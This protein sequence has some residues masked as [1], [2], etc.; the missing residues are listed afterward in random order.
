ML[1][2]QLSRQR[3]DACCISSSSI[4]T[5]STGNVHQTSHN[6]NTDGSQ[7]P[8][9][10]EWCHAVQANGRSSVV[11]TIGVKPGPSPISSCTLLH[12]EYSSALPVISP[13]NQEQ[14]R[15]TFFVIRFIDSNVGRSSTASLT[16]TLPRPT[17]SRLLISAPPLSIWIFTTDSSAKRRHART[18]VLLPSEVSK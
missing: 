2:A 12:S 14:C 1:L 7:C 4:G 5:F 8:S 13:F 18:Y 16:S 11:L 6:R 15:A 3:I 17:P 10:S 9:D